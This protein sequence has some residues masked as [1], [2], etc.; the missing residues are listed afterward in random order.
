MNVRVL[1]FA[2]IR[3]LLGRE[4]TA[5]SLHD[6]A[7]ISH[8]WGALVAETPALGQFRASTRVARN[9]SMASGDDELSDGDELALLPPTGGG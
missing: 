1:A 6:G 8:V 9:G 2:R 5:L 4:E 7:R 3:E